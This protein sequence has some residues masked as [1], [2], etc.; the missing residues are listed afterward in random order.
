M[1]GCPEFRD[2]VVGVMETATRNV[3]FG[4]DAAWTIAD[5]ARVSFAD[6]VIDLFFGQLRSDEVW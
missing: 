4:T 2:D 3:L 6:A 5:A 1:G